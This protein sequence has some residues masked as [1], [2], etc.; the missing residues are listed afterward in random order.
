MDLTCACGCVQN[1]VEQ[2][3][4]LEADQL[5]ED[6]A[7][8]CIFG[9]LLNDVMIMEWTDASNP[10]EH[11]EACDSSLKNFINMMKS[12][13]RVHTGTLY[14]GTDYED[15]K[16][17]KVGDVIDY[18]NRCTSWS[19][20]LDRA[21]NYADPKYPILL[22]FEGSMAALDLA[23]MDRDDHTRI[24]GYN[25]FTVTKVSSFYMDSDEVEDIKIQKRVFANMLVS[26]DLNEKV[27]KVEKDDNKVLCKIYRVKL[28]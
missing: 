1:F 22:V 5:A 27:K 16:H 17:L 7:I 26:D 25:K 24:V 21:I 10:W 12:H 2:A 13:Q 18:T 15:Y 28:V 19:P 6:G 3:K 14:R 9:S 20:K 23:P 8:S 11:I 4:D